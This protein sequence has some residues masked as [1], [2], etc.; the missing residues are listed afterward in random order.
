M[1][2]KHREMFIWL[3]ENRCPLPQQMSNR[4]ETMPYKLEE[5]VWRRMDLTER[6]AETWSQIP[7]VTITD[8]QASLLA[9]TD[10]QWKTMTDES[11]LAAAATLESVFEALSRR[12][13][14]TFRARVANPEE[15]TGILMSKRY[16]SVRAEVSRLQNAMRSL[17]AIV[18][19]KQAASRAAERR[20]ERS[21]YQLR[22]ALDIMGSDVDRLNTSE[23]VMV[24]YV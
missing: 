22:T 1:Q 6:E 10:E 16:A 3:R 19:V 4:P 13:R 23:T 2:G 15:L 8:E 24:N 14:L 21:S 5:V 12:V 20:W 11:L 7:S 9:A 18:Q 17:E